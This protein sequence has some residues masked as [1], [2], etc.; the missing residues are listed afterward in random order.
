MRVVTALLV[1]LG[2]TVSG[3]FVKP[4]LLICRIAERI[5]RNADRPATFNFS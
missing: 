3:L 4:K 2:L 1:W 5:F